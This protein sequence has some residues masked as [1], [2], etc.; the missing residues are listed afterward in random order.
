[1]GVFVDVMFVVGI[2]DVKVVYVDDLFVMCYGDVYIGDEVCI[3]EV[4]GV[5]V[6]FVLLGVV[7]R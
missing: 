4:L 6:D 7:G 5:M 2:G 1:M 3:D